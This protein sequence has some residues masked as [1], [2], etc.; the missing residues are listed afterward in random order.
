MTV[1]PTASTDV[2]EEVKEMVI[3]HS[4]VDYQ[5]WFWTK[6]DRVKDFA[7][8]LIQGSDYF[9]SE[10]QKWFASRKSLPV[11]GVVLCHGVGSKWR[12]FLCDKSWTDHNSIRVKHVQT[13]VENLWGLETYR[14][15][16]KPS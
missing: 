9:V 11:F 5:E 2:L 3:G 14:V 7:L 10:A 6:A 16:I 4:L 15:K 12:E 8:V 1:M 13:G